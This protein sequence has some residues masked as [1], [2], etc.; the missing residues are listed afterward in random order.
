MLRPR[1]R[2]KDSQRR[3]F[4]DK[5]HSIHKSLS[6]Q[7]DDDNAPR[8]TFDKPK[9]TSTRIPHYRYTNWPIYFDSPVIYPYSVAMMHRPRRSE[10][11]PPAH[12]AS[13]E[14]LRVDSSSSGTNATWHTGYQPNRGQFQGM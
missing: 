5:R 2:N 10:R 13:A 9:S 11:N 6:V 3:W 1:I 12:P 14:S 4:A 8:R 7:R